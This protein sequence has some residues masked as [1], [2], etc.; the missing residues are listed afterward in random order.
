MIVY[1]SVLFG[2]DSLNVCFLSLLCG[3]GFGFDDI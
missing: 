2:E 3:F 1:L